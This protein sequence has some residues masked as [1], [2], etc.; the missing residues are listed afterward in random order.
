[1]TESLHLLVKH[2]HTVIIQNP[3]YEVQNLIIRF[4]ITHDNMYN[5]A[6]RE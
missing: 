3:I 2:C 1:M 4:K 6:G 5:L